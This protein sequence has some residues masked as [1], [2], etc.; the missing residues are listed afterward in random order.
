MTDPRSGGI[1]TATPQQQVCRTLKQ[2]CQNSIN[3]MVDVD[4]SAADLTVSF[5]RPAGNFAQPPGAG[6]SLS[7][8]HHNIFTV[9]VRVTTIIPRILSD[10]SRLIHKLISAAVRMPQFNSGYSG[11]RRGQSPIYSYQQVASTNVKAEPSGNA[12]MTAQSISFIE[13]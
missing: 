4:E 11:A 12:L 6:S 10:S 3:D 8:V 5:S 1:L 13:R 2:I 9:S 7:G